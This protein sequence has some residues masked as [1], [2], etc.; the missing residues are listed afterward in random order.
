M[1]KLNGFSPHWWIFPVSVGFILV[2]IG[3]LKKYREQR[4]PNAPLI[5]KVATE[6]QFLYSGLA[7]IFG[8]VGFLIVSIY[9]ACTGWV[10]K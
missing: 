5:Y 1:D 3:L 8:G 7:A 9:Q 10:A 6:V 4:N 2:G